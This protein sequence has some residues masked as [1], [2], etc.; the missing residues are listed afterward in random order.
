M[1]PVRI[2]EITRRREA[3]WK[4]DK[5]TLGP[6]D[7]TTD[8]FSLKRQVDAI[9]A[10]RGP[11]NQVTPEERE[12]MA[13]KLSELSQGQWYNDVLQQARENN[14]D[15]VG[16]EHF[17]RLISEMD[18]ATMDT[19]RTTLKMIPRTHYQPEEKPATTHQGGGDSDTKAGEGDASFVADNSLS[20]RIHQLETELADRDQTVNGLEK[21]VEEKAEDEKKCCEKIYA[22]QEQNKKLEEQS[23]TTARLF[24]ERVKRDEMKRSDEKIAFENEINSLKNNLAHESK[25]N[26]NLIGKESKQS[27]KRTIVE[28]RDEIKILEEEKKE[29]EKENEDLEVKNT[30]MQSELGRRDYLIAKQDVEL[31]TKDGQLAER[32]A[33]IAARDKQM[34]TMAL[35]HGSATQELKAKLEEKEKELRKANESNI[36]HQSSEKPDK[37][38]FNGRVGEQINQDPREDLTKDEEIAKLRKQLED[39]K[40][41]RQVAEEKDQVAGRKDS[42]VQESGQKVEAES[43]AIKVSDAT[44]QTVTPT[45]S[46]ATGGPAGQSGSAAQV[47]KRTH[48]KPSVFNNN[49]DEIIRKLQAKARDLEEHSTTCLNE[50]QGL[51]EETRQLKVENTK[52]KADLEAALNQ[53]ATQP[54][55]TGTPPNGEL[56]GE[57]Q[58]LGAETEELKAKNKAHE[59]YQANA[60]V[61]FAED[62]EY[63]KKQED[64]IEKL[65]QKYETEVHELRQEN[66]KLHAELMKAQNHQTAIPPSPGLIPLVEE[67]KEVEVPTA[68]PR[69]S[70]DGT[71]ELKALISSLE[72]GKQ[73]A[74]DELQK[75]QAQLQQCRD[76]G[77]E[78][79]AQASFMEREKQQAI[80]ELQR[81]QARI[82]PPSIGSSDD[83]DCSAEDLKPE[84][85]QPEQLTALQARVNKLQSE[86]EKRQN[87][88]KVLQQ[89]ISNL[90]KEKDALETRLQA[91][92]AANTPLPDETPTYD[93]DK[94]TKISKLQDR[95]RGLEDERDILDNRVAELEAENTKVG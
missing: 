57:V 10:L 77:E 59:D 74:D 71:K 33:D 76:H 1:D 21:K 7:K 72:Q 15:H 12:A 46:T 86:L 40:Y 29:K 20:T 47:L 89:K 31:V 66:G 36:F 70:D 50:K 78:L 22:L 65:Q 88:G 68:E 91:T 45:T 30:E 41:H 3:A 93:E 13:R 25:Q 6:T 4:Q 42:E 63:M 87:H 84:P 67:G 8:I 5:S 58:R 85:P 53:E 54:A 14:Q 55:P 16:S 80:E 18:K 38:Q 61:W 83:K 2:A 81:V 92:V 11:D 64:E 60:K 44:T 35:A 39:C 49:K 17:R 51:E 94:D 19:V 43:P 79:R 62:D 90:E 34:E 82:P 52:L 95:G 24:T 27:K 9:Y 32:Q 69:K 26:E 73:Q 28:L 23:A 56:I 75:V 48:P 37:F